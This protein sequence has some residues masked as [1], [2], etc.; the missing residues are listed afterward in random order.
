LVSLFATQEIIVSGW[1]NIE[2]AILMSGKSIELKPGSTILGQV[3]SPLVK[4]DSG[5]VA[6]Y[7]SAI[8]SF[9][10]DSVG[11]RQKIEILGGAH[12]EGLVALVGTSPSS[13]QDNIVEI[14]PRA[15]I[16]GAAYS[17]NRMTLDGTVIGTVFTKDFYFYEAPTQYLGW[18]RNGVID[19]SALA[20]S[21]LVP[22]Q[23]PGADQM[24][25]LDWL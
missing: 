20:P 9:P 12:V 1:A 17:E 15:V 24:D 22:A 11:E 13:P 18:V 25:V 10:V 2:H 19:R 4:V 6:K 7:P 5:A 16:I 8:I 21:F 3:L 14:Q 23:F